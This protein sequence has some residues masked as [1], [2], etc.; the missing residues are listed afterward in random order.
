MIKSSIIELA[1]RQARKT[2]VTLKRKNKYRVGAVLFDKKRIIS[3]GN[4]KFNKTH[5]SSPH[6]F[7]AICAEWDCV[8]GIER[9]EL[10]F[11]SLCVVRINSKGE[12]TMSRPCA[13]C[14][15]FLSASGIRKVYW[16]DFEGRMNLM[17]F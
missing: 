12:L 13:F 15:K 17:N 5:P 11:A 6:S 3:V 14:S 9:D 2:D 16:S 4:N 1:I 7:K 8:F 10:K